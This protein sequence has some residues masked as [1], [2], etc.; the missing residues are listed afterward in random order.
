MQVLQAGSARLIIFLRRRLSSRAQD[1]CRGEG[2]CWHSSYGVAQN[3]ASSGHEWRPHY[4]EKYGCLTK[5]G[6]VGYRGRS[7][8]YVTFR[9]DSLAKVP[10]DLV[11][12]PLDDDAAL[13]DIEDE[14]ED[15]ETGLS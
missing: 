9:P 5:G 8:K 1:G 15:K 14:N 2:A 12:V 3:T 7:V 11:A 4:D 10:I 6:E 13:L